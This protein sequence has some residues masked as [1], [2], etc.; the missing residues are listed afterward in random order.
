MDGLEVGRWLLEGY[1]EESRWNKSRRIG[2][3]VEGLGWEVELWEV[4][5]KGYGGL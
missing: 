3:I 4:E 2:G 5:L 1:G